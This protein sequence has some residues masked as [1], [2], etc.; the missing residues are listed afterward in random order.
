MGPSG[1]GKTTLLRIILGLE[2]ADQGTII[3]SDPS[4]GKVQHP[5]QI[6]VVFQE[7]RLLDFTTAIKN[8]QFVEGKEGR[9][10]HL[11]PHQR[12]SPLQL[13]EQDCNQPER[14]RLAPS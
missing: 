4:T 2:Q 7:N 12:H 3:W 8:I 9:R 1:I 5:G 6:S 11:L 13:D 10:N 14:L